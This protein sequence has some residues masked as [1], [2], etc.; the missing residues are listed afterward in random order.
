MNI[1]LLE[2]MASRYGIACVGLSELRGGHVSSVYEFTRQGQ[3]CILRI[4][5]SNEEINLHST[6]QV[7]EWMAFLAERGGPVC[8]PCLS[9]RGRLIEAARFKGQRYLAIAFEKARGVLAEEMRPEEWD[10][11]LVQALGVAIGSWHRIASEYSPTSKSRR[12]TWNQ[13]NNCFNPL[14][15]LD[16]ADSLILQK[17]SPLLEE[18]SRLPVDRENYGLAHIDLH[19]GNFYVDT[20]QLQITLIDF[21]DCAYGWYVMDLAMLLFDVLV[22]YG[23][24][25]R[26][27]FGEHFLEQLLHGYCTQKFLGRFWMAQF[28]IFL[29]LLELGLYCMLYRDY[30]P[31]EAGEWESKFMPGRRERIE[32]DCRYVDLDFEA[33]YDRACSL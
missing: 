14:K 13:M 21:D 29:R 3:E 30:D 5:P 32:G 9:S 15:E 26:E 7:L 2:K 17:R 31:A 4:T 18:T 23:G 27:K 10:D 12:P 8:R 16:D 1:D 11:T 25:E 33:I 22:L 20:G 24:S 6:R 19:F 28:P